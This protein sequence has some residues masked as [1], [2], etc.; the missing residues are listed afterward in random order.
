[1]IKEQTNAEK[2][3]VKT[4]NVINAPGLKEQAQSWVTMAQP[5]PLTFLCTADKI[6]DGREVIRM[7]GATNASFLK[8]KTEGHGKA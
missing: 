2:R 4:K 5:K 1:M 3:I 7:Q 8:T 6:N